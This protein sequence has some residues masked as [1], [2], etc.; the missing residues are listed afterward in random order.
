MVQLIHPNLGATL[1]QAESIKGQRQQNRLAELLQPYQVQRQQAALTG[2]NLA[3]QQQQGQI[4]DQQIKRMTLLTK[5]F[6][7]SLGDGFDQLPDEEK[8]LRWQTGMGN[9]EALGADMQGMPLEYSPEGM[10]FVNALSERLGLNSGGFGKQLVNVRKAD[11]SLAIV[12]ASEEGGVKEISGYTPVALTPEAQAQLDVTTTGA[13]EDAKYD[14]RIEKGAAAE[15]AK[16]AGAQAVKLSGEAF[17]QLSGVRENITQL[18]EVVRLIDEGAQTGEVASRLP[19]ITE[20]SKSLDNLQARMGLNVVQNT[21]F[22][23][24]SEGEL[25]LA[26]NTALPKN[27]DPDALREWAI[28]KKAAQEKLAN[29]LDEVATYL[30]TPGNTIAGWLEAQRNRRRSERQKSAPSTN[31]SDVSTEDLLNGL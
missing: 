21:T 19:S 15:G 16:Q 26:L 12:Q 25:A 30:G 6:K 9:I 11:G 17:E 27:K 2:A 5:V 23:A 7:D 22:G 31:L 20:A 29:Y 3:N 14:A 28:E 13:K 8:A 18:D 24:L 1:A 4:S 10:Q